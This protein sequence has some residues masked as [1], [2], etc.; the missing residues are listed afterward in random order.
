MKKPVELASDQPVYRFRRGGVEGSNSYEGNSFTTLADAIQEIRHGTLPATNDACSGAGPP[1][2]EILCCP[3]SGTYGTGKK[4]R[5]Q[6]YV[7]PRSAGSGGDGSKLAPW[8]S[9]PMAADEL[10]HLHQIGEL[11][12]DAGQYLCLSFCEMFTASSLEKWKKAKETFAKYIFMAMAMAL[13]VPV[14]VIL[15]YILSKAWPVLSPSFV[16]ENPRNFM[17]SGG[18]WAPLVGTFFLVWISLL[19]AAPVGILAGVYLNEYAHDNWFT[20]MINLAVVNLAGVP[21]IVHALFGVGAFVLFMG[22][23][24]SLLAASCTLA[25]MTLPVII[26]STRE[27]L[28]AVPMSFREACWNMG[29]SRWQ[30]IRTIVLPNSI[31]GILTGVILQVSR[32]AGETAPILFTGAVFFTPVPDHGWESF[33]PYSLNDRCMALSMHLFTLATQVRGVSDE[34]Q[35]GTAAVLI[36]LVLVVNSLS[37]SLR[38]VLR[39]RKKW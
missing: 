21:S 29:A 22:M 17:T 18:I 11:D 38:V 30:T 9:L 13:V 7:N 27:A 28:A 37:I 5:Y 1:H 19:V 6:F 16:L 26:T 12:L 8:W 35:Y 25:V 31:G 15:A 34:L 20:R 10:L 23:G 39:S 3:P 4:P 32:A 2:F 24:R 33:F 14:V 36:G